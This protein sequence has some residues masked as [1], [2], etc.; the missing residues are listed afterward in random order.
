MFT[1]L[2]KLNFVFKL[3]AIKNV[4]IVLIVKIPLRNSSMIKSYKYFT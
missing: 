2:N 4:E 3:L 1:V